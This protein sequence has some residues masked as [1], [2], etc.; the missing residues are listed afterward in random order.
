MQF[1][2]AYK[3]CYVV[4]KPLY[5]PV[6]ACRLAPTK[7]FYLVQLPAAPPSSKHNEN[8]KLSCNTLHS[9]NEGLFSVAQSL[10]AHVGVGQIYVY[11]NTHMQTSRHTDLAK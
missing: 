1:L 8:R 2:V 4:F 9:L 11:T 10:L 7:L 6:T 3:A 5:T